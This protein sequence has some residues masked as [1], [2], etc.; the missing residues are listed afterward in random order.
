L[1]IAAAYASVKPSVCNFLSFPLNILPEKKLPNRTTFEL[2]CSFVIDEFKK[3]SI[4][5]SSGLVVRFVAGV[6]RRRFS[7]ASSQRHSDG[8]VH[9]KPSKALRQHFVLP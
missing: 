1:D 8:P 2:F 6:R 4:K 3:L 7:S 5:L 9:A